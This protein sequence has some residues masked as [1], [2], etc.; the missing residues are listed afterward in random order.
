MSRDD[1]QVV[2]AWRRGDPEAARALFERHVAVLGRF[3]ST[4]VGVEADDLVQ[5]TF[6][7]ALSN[8]DRFEGRSSFR[9]YL[10]GVANNVLL[11]HLRTRYA[12]GRH[13]DFDDVT[14]RDL[15]TSASRKLAKNDD[16][17]RLLESLASLPLHEQVALELYYWEELP[18][19]EIAEALGVPEGTVR[20]RIRSARLKLRRRLGAIRTAEARTAP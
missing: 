11:K 20:T 17:R 6:M 8:P 13:L 18:A 4:K 15:G 16:R 14:L 12:R 10:L 5:L 2:R 3:F 7:T 19:S 9:S 1:A